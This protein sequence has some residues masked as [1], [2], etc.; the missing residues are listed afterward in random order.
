[1]TSLQED[2]ETHTA[3]LGKAQEISTPDLVR[4]RMSRKVISVSPE[5]PLVEVARV[6]CE[7]HW[8]RVPVLDESRLLGGMIS[9]MDVLAAMVQSHDE[10]AAGGG[11]S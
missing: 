3:V 6:M 9:T 11:S 8:H 7:G 5:T 10:P 1:M 4:D 2:P